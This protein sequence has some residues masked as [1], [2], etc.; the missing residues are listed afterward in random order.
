MF[1]YDNSKVETVGILMMSIG[2]ILWFFKTFFSFQLSASVDLFGT[3]ALL[4]GIGIWALGYIKK[5]KATKKVD[6]L[7]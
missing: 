7:N 1:T 6:K 2:V 3:Y 4:L 5:V